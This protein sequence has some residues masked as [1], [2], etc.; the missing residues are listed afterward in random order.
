MRK[1]VVVEYDPQWPEM[2]AAEAEKLKAVFGRE[3]TAI[4]HIGSTSVPGLKA[5]PIIDI[6][7]I[8]KDIGAVDRFNEAMIRLGYEPLGEFGIPGRR[9]F[10]KGGEKRTHHVHV[11]QEGSKEALRH[12]AF[13]DYLRAHPEEAGQ[14]GELKQRL[15]GRFPDD[16]ESYMD[17]KDGFIKAMEQKALAWWKGEERK[18][19][20]N[21]D[22][23]DAN[24]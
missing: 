20:N 14:Y 22:G 7:P 21:A 13:R 2:F 1:V 12:M 10:P 16:I 6:M 4:H 11:F 15:A 9:F 24:R 17:G 23:S 5:K 8:V 18:G 3:L 19:G